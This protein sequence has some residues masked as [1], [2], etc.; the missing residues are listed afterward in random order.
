MKLPK[1]ITSYFDVVKLE[2]KAWDYLFMPNSVEYYGWYDITKQFRKVLKRL[3]AE[4]ILVD[5][6]R[7]HGQNASNRFFEITSKISLIVPK[8]YCKLNTI[9]IISARYLLKV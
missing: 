9:K 7:T 1:Y 4:R 8:D 6:L 3:K 2:N 5:F